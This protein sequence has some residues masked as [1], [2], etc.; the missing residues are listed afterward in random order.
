MKA[1]DI[2]RT[3]H[4]SLNSEPKKEIVV[5]NQTELNNV[6]DDFVGD[7]II[8]FNGARIPRPYPRAWIKVKNTNSVYVFDDVGGIYNKYHCPR[9]IAHDYAV[10]CAHCGTVR[11]NDASSVKAFGTCVVYSYDNS[12][13]CAKDAT[14]VYGDG[15]CR[16]YACNDSSVEACDHASVYA[17]NRAL[18]YALDD[19][20]VIAHGNACI[21]A[22]NQS[23]ISAYNN[24][25]VEIHSSADPDIT[26][27]GD[28]RIVNRYPHTDD[29]I[30]FLD[31]HEIQHTDT[32]AIFYKAVVKR[33]DRYLAQY[34][35]D[36]GKDFEYKI[37]K[38]KRIYVN[39]DVRRD[40]E[41]GIHIASLDW[42]LNY[43]F[44][45]IVRR[46]WGDLAILEVEVNI[47]D[48]V[49][50]TNSTGKVRTNRV[51]VLRE[52]P[53]EECG[54]L[55]KIIARRVEKGI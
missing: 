46:S 3:S 24:V 54:V 43:G 37:G 50:P 34:S 55:G 18:V 21:T 49:L 28:A 10:V 4:F 9:I 22:Y 32:K 36:E 23:K 33:D 53:L 38:V 45:T 42:A 47:K 14:H 41:K 48:I 40:C 25:L 19:S 31:Y 30:K 6:A 51:K 7:I 52:V 2:L 16:V 1:V 35:L 39:K 8:D 20:T 17:T 13:V 5:K 27:H 29:I 26:L 11:A 44:D 12:V 15:H